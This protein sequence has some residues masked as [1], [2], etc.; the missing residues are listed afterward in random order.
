MITK[1]FAALITHQ[2]ID[3]TIPLADEPEI[4]KQALKD[5]KAI[6]R[7]Q[8]INRAKI[9]GVFE[10][11]GD[12]F[13]R[14]DYY[15]TK[16]AED[17][18]AELENKITK[19]TGSADLGS[20]LAFDLRKRYMTND[21]IEVSFKVD[22]EKLEKM[23]KADPRDAAIDALDLVIAGQGNVLDSMG[24]HKDPKWWKRVITASKK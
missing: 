6:P 12:P 3:T 20:Y 7:R 8:I 4:A 14:S 11:K 1:R 9:R 22:D 17:Y 2:G 23:K 10:D 21:Y 19:K 13:S 18:I 15:W 16:K 24:G 5:L